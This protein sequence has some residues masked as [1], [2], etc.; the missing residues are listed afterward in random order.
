[1]VKNKTGGS[2]TK[3]MAR[4]HLKPSNIVR[5]V[6]KPKD[7]EILAR[8]TRINGGSV[9]E[10]LCNDLVNRQMIIRRKFKGRHKRDNRINIDTIVIVGLRDWEIL[11]GKKKEKVDLLYVYNMNEL[12]E[13]KKIKGLKILPEGEKVEEDSPFYIDKNFEPIGEEDNELMK[14]ELNKKIEESKEK[15]EDKEELNF[16]WDDI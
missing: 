12:D 11:N 5:K 2:N 13:L 15:K 14:N 16:D 10:V 8:V 9:C 6:R 3:R 1:M 7:G 4:K